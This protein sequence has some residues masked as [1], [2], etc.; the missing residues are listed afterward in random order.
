MTSP[1]VFG[2]RSG[3]CGGSA[4]TLAASATAARYS[5]V[6]ATNPIDDSAGK[7]RR[8]EH[9]LRP[10]DQL[11]VDCEHEH[12]HSQRLRSVD[13]LGCQHERLAGRR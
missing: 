3:T 8:A 10:V 7:Q 4:V 5:S 13:E 6:D 1:Y 11:D 12:D 9:R 2:F